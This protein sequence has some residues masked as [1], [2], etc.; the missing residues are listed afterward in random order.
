MEARK[1]TAVLWSGLEGANRGSSGQLRVATV[2]KRQARDNK[3]G[4][5][6][7]LLLV[8]P[9]PRGKGLGLGTRE[10]GL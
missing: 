8:S 10:L 9:H 5:Q 3:A 6:D 7:T 4:R 1:S 2:S